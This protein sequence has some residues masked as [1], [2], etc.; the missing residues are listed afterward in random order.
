MLSSWFKRNTTLCHSLSCSLVVVLENE[1]MYGTSFEVSDE[2]MSDEFVLPI[3]KAKI[4][5]PG[6]IFLLKCMPLSNFSLLP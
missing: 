5:Q 6:Q 3:G 1:I 2:V 4:E